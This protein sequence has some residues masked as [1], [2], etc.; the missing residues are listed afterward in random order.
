M[1]LTVFTNS[2]DERH[3]LNIE[4][5]NPFKR[6]RC[7]VNEQWRFQYDDGRRILL[8]TAL[9]TKIEDESQRLKDDGRL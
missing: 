7:A 9:N 4:E 5:C 2:S 1:K 3:L 6:V 8:K